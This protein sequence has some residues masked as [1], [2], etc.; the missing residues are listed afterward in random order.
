MDEEE[1]DRKLSEMGIVV[2]ER[3][4]K[5]LTNILTSTN[6]FI[7]SPPL[8]ST[9]N[10]SSIV[11]ENGIIRDNIFNPVIDD[12]DKVSVFSSFSSS[13]KVIASDSQSPQ[14]VPAGS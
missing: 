4:I 1:I 10:S 13:N 9:F 14:P 5:N 3:D 7:A 6:D 2:E 12:P 8:S 11:Y